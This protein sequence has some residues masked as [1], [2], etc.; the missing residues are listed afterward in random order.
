MAVTACF[1]K[2][3]NDLIHLSYSNFWRIFRSRSKCRNESTENTTTIVL[4]YTS[5]RPEPERKKKFWEDW[6]S[7]LCFIPPPPKKNYNRSI[8]FVIKSSTTLRSN[9]FIYWSILTRSI[10]MDIIYHTSSHQTSKRSVLFKAY[11]TLKAGALVKFQRYCKY[12]IS[13]IWFR[14]SEYYRVQFNE[15]L[16]GF[17]DYRTRHNNFFLNIFCVPSRRLSPY[18]YIYHFGAPVSVLGILSSSI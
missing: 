5:I 2:L 13:T 14:R 9:L 4:K 16:K 3:Q 8:T 12:I 17:Y 11:S 1:F 6:F 18:I 7:Y 15:F 10:Y